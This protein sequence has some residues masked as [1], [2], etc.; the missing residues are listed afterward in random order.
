MMSGKSKSIIRT[1]G[2][3]V[4]ILIVSGIFA[5]RKY[6]RKEIKREQQFEQSKTIIKNQKIQQ[7]KHNPYV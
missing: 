4:L 7:Q 5:Y 3:L 1:I 6:Y 2:M